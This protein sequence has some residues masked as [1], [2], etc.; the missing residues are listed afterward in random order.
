MVTR[1]GVRHSDVI[2]GISL[3][4]TLSVLSAAQIVDIHGDNAAR[5]FPLRGPAHFFVKRSHFGSVQT[6]WIAVLKGTVKVTLVDSTVA[7][8]TSPVPVGRKTFG[9]FFII[10]IIASQNKFLNKQQFSQTSRT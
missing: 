10:G 3:I 5:T 9:N 8:S 1:G 7:S 2:A 6:T 4:T